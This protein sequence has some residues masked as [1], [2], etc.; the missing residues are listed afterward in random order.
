MCFMPAAIGLVGYTMGYALQRRLGMGSRQGPKKVD[1]TTSRANSMNKIKH[2]RF[3]L[4]HVA[5]RH[6]TH[7]GMINFA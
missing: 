3:R 2:F 6:I 5:P 7:F 1:M 4:P